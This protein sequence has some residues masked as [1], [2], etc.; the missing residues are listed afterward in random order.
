[1]SQYLGDISAYALAVSQGYTGTEE[2]YAELM[3]SYATV[4]QTAVTAAQTATTKASEAA[5]SA[6]TA[7][8]KA[9][10]ATTAATTATTKA[11]EA[12]TSA[13]T[14][15]SA[16]DTAV[17]AASTA[18]TKATEATTA[19]ATAT[20]AATTATT[21]KDDAVSA[22]TA[23][24]TAQTGAETAAA[25]VQSSAAQIATNTA[26][27]SQLKSDLTEIVST[28]T[29]NLGR[30]SGWE[31][32]ECS[33][34][35]GETYRMSLSGIVFPRTVYL[36]FYVISTGTA[37]QQMEITQESDVS[38]EF[39]P[40]YDYSYIEL[41]LT[42]SNA[43]DIIC[44]IKKSIIAETIESIMEEKGVIDIT[45]SELP[46]AIMNGTKI[47]DNTVSNEKQLRSVYKHPFSTSFGGEY[48]AKYYTML[49]GRKV[50]KI[51]LDGDSITGEGYR[52]PV[53][54]NIML[55]GGY[56]ERGSDGSMTPLYELVNNGLGG[57][58][59]VEWVGTG[60]EYTFA[61]ETIPA[62]GLLSTA[63]ATNPD[64]LIIAFGTNDAALDENTTTI[65]ERLTGLANRMEEGLKRIRG[66][67]AVNGREAYGKTVNDLGVVICVPLGTN[68]GNRQIDKWQTFVQKIYANLAREYQCAFVDFS[69]PTF[70]V[71]SY[72]A[73]D[74]WGDIGVSDASI[75]PSA[76]F[77][78]YYASVLQPIVFPFG[79]WNYYDY[80]TALIPKSGTS[81]NKP[82]KKPIYRGYTYYSTTLGK[83]IFCASTGTEAVG[84][85]TIGTMASASDYSD[86]SISLRVGNARPLIRLYTYVYEYAEANRPNDI[87]GFIAEYISMSLNALGYKS[88]VNGSSFTLANTQLGTTSYCSATDS[89]TGLT[90]T[91]SLEQGTENTWVDADGVTI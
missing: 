60:E 34:E 69:I 37:Y 30:Y 45:L 58:T 80:D 49:N 84:T 43:N 64:L 40:D 54:D 5:T 8:N 1:M 90:I 42:S 77:S 3:A 74:L 17:S 21:A 50:I 81:S 10:E 2:E 33:L 65:E 46:C 68:K 52:N 55:T 47:T 67:E 29:I 56:A 4:G 66:T 31:Q 35:Q 16:K 14:A 27:I 73:L 72:D 86:G 87:S 26:D 28:T 12:S 89:G 13:S 32:K 82:S 7:T 61:G 75:H 91:A 39:V 41:G 18:T 76:S 70:D 15:T 85:F 78:K 19:A 24:Q 6:T 88:E 53:I 23:A 48:L 11:G 57:A 83:P 62:N 79:F 63:M 71:T 59:T 20:S 9:T 44:T 38:F 22:K 51:T 25:S 36:R